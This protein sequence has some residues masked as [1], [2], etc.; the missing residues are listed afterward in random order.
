MI[1]IS[2]V[3]LCTCETWAVTLKEQSNLVKMT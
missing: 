2:P 3:V 1:V